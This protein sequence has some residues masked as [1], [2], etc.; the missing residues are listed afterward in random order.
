MSLELVTA[1][2]RTRGKSP[3]EFTYQGYGKLAE[4]KVMGK[5]NQPLV[6]DKD[7]KAVE[8]ELDADRAIVLSEGQHYIFV[9]DLD[10]SG[11]VTA[12]DFDTV[13]ALFEGDIVKML[14]ATLIAK[15]AENRKAASPVSETV[16]EDE[17]TPIVA[18]LTEAGILK[19]ED[20][21]VWRRTLTGGA[22]QLEMS[23]LDYVKLTKEYKA[24]VKAGKLA[25]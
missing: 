13:L 11:V 2:A 19:A 7:G 15:N 18:S 3:Q 12:E 24:G 9:D 4:R 20:V 16:T 10:V 14:E 21:A 22:K 25:A 1:R 6:I 8:P 5:E 17:L 23:R